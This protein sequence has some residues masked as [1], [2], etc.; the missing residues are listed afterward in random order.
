[1]R[2]KPTKKKVKQ[3]PVTSVISAAPVQDWYQSL[4][5]W[6][7]AHNDP[8]WNAP[9]LFCVRWHDGR[10]MAWDVDVV[11]D[12]YFPTKALAKLAR[13]S[14]PKGATVT[15]GPDHGRYRG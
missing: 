8:D 1:M 2:V 5:A 11:E 6:H 13:D 14:L 9:R 12:V 7:D 10:M 3:Q 15:K 4:R